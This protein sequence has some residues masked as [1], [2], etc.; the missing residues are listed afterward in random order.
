M[1][2]FYV[3]L[4]QGSKSGYPWILSKNDNKK[5][6]K[7]VIF[8]QNW[9]KIKKMAQNF[10]LK[11]THFKLIFRVDQFMGGPTCEN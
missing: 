9:I 10:R 11:M 4:K 2:S 8:D 3:F 5:L 1:T 7:N 6:C